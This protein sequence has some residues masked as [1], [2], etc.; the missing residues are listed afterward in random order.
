MQFGGGEVE[1][2]VSLN[3]LEKGLRLC[4]SVQ[5]GHHFAVRMLS[6][7]WIDS[8]DFVVQLK[9]LHGC[10][11]LSG[12]NE[13]VLGEAVAEPILEEVTQMG[14]CRPLEASFIVAFIAAQT[15]G[16]VHVAEAQAQ[17]ER[18]HSQSFGEHLN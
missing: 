17:Q 2:F 11:S 3:G 12:L 7:L 10:G 9:V 15:F 8:Q 6:C 4:I 16:V 1:A 14:L 5:P 13:G 18:E